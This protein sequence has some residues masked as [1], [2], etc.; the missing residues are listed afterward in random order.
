MEFSVMSPAQAA[1]FSSFILPHV[2][3]LPER[4]NFWYLCAWEDGFGLVGLAVVD[5]KPEEA[6]LLSLAISPPKQRQGIGS[7][8]IGY[9]IGHLYESGI[10]QLEI[11]HSLPANSWP[12]LERFLLRAGFRLENESNV[13]I[14]TFPLSKLMESPLAKAFV[15][16]PRRNGV[17]PLRQV[18]AYAFRTLSSYA[19]KNG[20]FGPL[21]QTDYH[22]DLSACYLDGDTITACFLIR[23]IGPNQ[24]E[25]S[26]TY[27]SSPKHGSA[28]LELLVF[29]AQQALALGYPPQLQVGFACLNE[30]SERLL[31]HLCGNEDPQYLSRQYVRSTDFSYHRPENWTPP[32]LQMELADDRDLQCAHCIHRTNR[33]TACG[34]YKSK[35]GTVLYGGACKY[36]AKS[37]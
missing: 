17:V 10:S 6:S 19:V 24:V 31:R 28:L 27:L 25:N 15:D 35:P 3:D 9:A 32:D 30:A 11:S 12:K 20:L 21:K 26:W 23:E 34:K 29:S 16:H 1:Q 14:F 18:P 36:F 8:L 2:R 13:G 7:A 4:D 5:P 33:L 37:E 22:P